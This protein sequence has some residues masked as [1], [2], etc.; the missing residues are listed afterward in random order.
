MSKFFN[1]L[2]EQDIRE[3]EQAN[4][5]CDEEYWYN[6]WLHEQHIINSYNK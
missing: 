5:L 2:D 6:Q 4:D 3:L 1:G